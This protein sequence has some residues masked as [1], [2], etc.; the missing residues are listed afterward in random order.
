MAV[1]K[2]EVLRQ[3]ISTSAQ[4]ADAGTDLEGIRNSSAVSH[5]CRWRSTDIRRDAF[6]GFLKP[7]ISFAFSGWRVLKIL[8]QVVTDLEPARHR[9]GEDMIGGSNAGIVVE[10]P[11]RH[12]EEVSLRN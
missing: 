11:G 10:R 4:D 3:N 9:A 5:R 7:G 2:L 12:D 8:R 1:M 6:A